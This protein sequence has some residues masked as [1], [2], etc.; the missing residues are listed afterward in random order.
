M[1]LYAYGWFRVGIKY[2]TANSTQKTGKAI[3]P[4]GETISIMAYFPLTILKG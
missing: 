2:M 4:C 1:R 3:L